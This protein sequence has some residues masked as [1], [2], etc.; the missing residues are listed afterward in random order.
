[1]SKKIK[2]NFDKRRALPMFAQKAKY[3]IENGLI[4]SY[5]VLKLIAKCGKALSTIPI[6]LQLFHLV[7]KYSYLVCKYSI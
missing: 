4:V 6:S 5:K 7:C 3:D 1:M 2:E